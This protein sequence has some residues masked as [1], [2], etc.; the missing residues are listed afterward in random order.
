MN[1]PDK[2]LI[3]RQKV[4]DELDVCGLNLLPEVKTLPSLV[5]TSLV[6]LEI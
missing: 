2:L 4:G 5:D 1:K 6:K 3:N